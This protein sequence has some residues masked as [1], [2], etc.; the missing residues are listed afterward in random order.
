MNA[1]WLFAEAYKYRRLHE[2]FSTSR[3]WKDYDVFFRQK[4]DAF[5]HTSDAVLGLA[6]RFNDLCNAEQSDRLKFWELARG[7]WEPP[8]R[9]EG[10]AVDLDFG[11]CAQCVCGATAPARVCSPI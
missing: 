2:C 8:L 5:V 3:W 1:P 9:N 11:T 6:M 7:G 4:C 10:Y